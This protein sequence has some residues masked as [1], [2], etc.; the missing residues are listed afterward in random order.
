VRYRAFISYSHADAAAAAWLHRKLEGWRVPARMRRE[1]PALPERLAPVFRDREDLA[2]GELG[3]LILSALAD[4]AALVV[5]CSP[6]AARSRWVDEE[7]RA[8]RASGRGDRV[9]ALIVAG[10]PGSGDGRE[11]FPPALREG[12]AELLAADLRPGRDGKELALLRLIS[13]LL[14]VPLDTL[15]QRES[16]RRHQ[17]LFAITTVALVVML[18]TSFLAVQAML[19]RRAAER[20]QK[21]AEALV[22]FMLG[23]L[24]NKLSEVGRLDILEGVHDQAMEYFQSLPDTDVTDLSLEQRAKALD[25]IG[26]VRREQ[27]DLDKALV[28]FLAA[29]KLSRRLAQAA[30]GNVARQLAHAEDLAYLGTVRWYQGDLD[31]AQAGFDAAQAVLLR[32]QPLAP[33]NTE[34]LFQLTTIAN[35][36]GHVLEGRGRLEEATREYRRMLEMAQKL[37]AIDAD[38]VDWQ[39]HLG[40]AH[41]NLA[42]MA[43]L[44]GDLAAAIEGYRADVAIELALARKD[45]RNNAQAERVLLARGALGRVLAFAGRLAEGAD[46]LQAAATS[47]ESLYRLEPDSASLLEDVAIYAN[48][49]ATL[50]RQQG[51]PEPAA[52][53]SQRALAATSGLLAKDAANPGWQR[54]HAEAL[55]ERARQ[56]RVAG[57]PAAA[58]TDLQQA[59]QVVEP[60]QAQQPEDR[61]LLLVTVGAQLELALLGTPESARP[62]LVRAL[63]ACDAQASGRLDPRLRAL[64]AELLLRLG[65]RD[66]GARLARALWRDGYRDAGFALLLREHGL[67]PTA[68]SNGL[69]AGDS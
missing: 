65:Q 48:S 4:S 27:G 38:S 30:P 50:R 39:N 21:Q 67:A 6:D 33:R 37:V 61:S 7:I 51:K 69:A 63:A 54:R 55:L 5:V 3:P 40:L 1:N 35:N 60:L 32:T 25:Q 44:R 24:N 43:L 20:R 13:G 28:S 52:Q 45:P 53:L 36:A 29:E 31:G 57:R 49:L 12:K 58:R 17:R 47:A 56:A 11:C 14:G 10:E 23:D 26:N 68:A 2:L 34:L 42:K 15:R 16:R 62:G 41:N 59:L 64:R 19:A 18:L 8:F 22:G 46:E 66:A 9:Y